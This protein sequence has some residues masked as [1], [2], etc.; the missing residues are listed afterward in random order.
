MDSWVSPRMDV[1][2]TIS[3]TKPIISQ[4]AVAPDTLG[5]EEFQRLQKK[6]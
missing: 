4:P 5:V 3:A 2:A 6:A 1:P